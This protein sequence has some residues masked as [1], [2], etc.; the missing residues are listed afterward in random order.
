MAA[1][2]SERPQGGLVAYRGI[3]VSQRL[4]PFLARLEA[5]AL[6]YGGRILW[7]SGYRSPQE[8]E[9]LQARHEAGDPS[10]PFEPLPY[11]L[12]KHATGDAAD[13]EASSP[14]VAAAVGAYAQSIGLGW[15]P[16]EPWH[17]EVR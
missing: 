6:A 8:Q 2:P 16:R 11:L 3:W 14:E 12:S 17:F 5:R 13:G 1:G 4:A 7:T 10:V 15:S 9:N